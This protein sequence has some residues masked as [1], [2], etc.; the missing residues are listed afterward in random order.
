[1]KGIFL[2][3]YIVTHNGVSSHRTCDDIRVQSEQLSANN[4]DNERLI[5]H[6]QNNSGSRTNHVNE[7]HQRH[8]LSAVPLSFVLSLPPEQL[9]AHPGNEVKFLDSILSQNLHFSQ[10]SS[11]PASQRVESDNSERVYASVPPDV[12]KKSVESANYRR[13]TLEDDD[14]CQDPSRFD[15][16]ACSTDVKEAFSRE[17]TRKSKRRNFQKEGQ[18]DSKRP[19]N[20]LK[21][22]K[23]YIKPLKIPKPHICPICTLSFRGSSQLK[24]HVKAVHDK[25]RDHKCSL[26]DYVTSRKGIL[27]RHMKMVHEKVRKYACELCTYRAG[28]KSDLERHVAQVHLKIK[29]FKCDLCNYASALKINVALHRRAI[30][31]KIKSYE[32][33]LCDFKS[34]YMHSLKLHKTAI[35]ENVRPIECDLCE[36]K[37]LSHKRVKYHKRQ[38]HE[39]RRFNCD[40]CEYIAATKNNLNSHT[41]QTRVAA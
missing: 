30:H 8:V 3:T 37:F 13:T 1:M 25:I 9:V 11:F 12:G 7:I 29:P 19:K 18:I 34:A 39:I 28:H 35:H 38:V 10:S 27:T 26:C 20:Q 33:N 40:Q 17:V 15:D 36:M 16:Q 2:L 32:C 24:E 6:L 5:N 21:S 41:R 14:G 4:P 23:S 31:E 22:S